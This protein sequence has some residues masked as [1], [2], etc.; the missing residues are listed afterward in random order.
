MF[1]MD[2]VPI[3]NPE[4]AWNG[5]AKFQRSVQLGLEDVSII[6]GSCRFLLIAK[7]DHSSSLRSRP[8]PAFGDGWMI[9]VDFLISQSCVGYGNHP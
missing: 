6:G 5:I 7:N 8:P 4:L 3:A 9:T 1:V 2:L